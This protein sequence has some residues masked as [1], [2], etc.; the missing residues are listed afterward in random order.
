M[1][2][3]D[4]ETMVSLA[5]LTRTL[6]RRP[7]VFAALLPW[8][9]GCSLECW[10]CGGSGTAPDYAAKGSYT[11]PIVLTDGSASVTQMLSVTVQ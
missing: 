4:P 3:P 10:G 8:L 1:M 5:D 11:V 7:V 9:P 6:D 2:G